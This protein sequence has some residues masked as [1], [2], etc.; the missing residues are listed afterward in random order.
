MWS[1][2][3]ATP[4]CTSIT[5]AIRKKREAANAIAGEWGHIRDDVERKRRVMPPVRRQFTADDLK[6]S[7]RHAGGGD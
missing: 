3:N 4:F 6:R 5:R 2:A 7:R 1:M